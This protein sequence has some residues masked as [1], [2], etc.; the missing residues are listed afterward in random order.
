M[1]VIITSDGRLI[2]DSAQCAHMTLLDLTIK[3]NL[4]GGISQNLNDIG[5]EIKGGKKTPQ[6]WNLVLVTNL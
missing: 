4:T 6:I 3:H 5:F 1:I 2:R